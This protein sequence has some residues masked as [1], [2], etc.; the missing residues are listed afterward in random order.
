MFAEVT[1]KALRSE[2]EEV[3]ASVL[4]VLWIICRYIMHFTVQIISFC[5]CTEQTVEGLSQYEQL[6]FLGFASHTSCFGQ[7]KVGNEIKN[8]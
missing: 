1:H 5:T 2:L 8:Q 4:A 6:Q 7:I 3:A